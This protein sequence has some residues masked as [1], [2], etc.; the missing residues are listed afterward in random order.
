MKVTIVFENHAGYRKGLIGYHGFSALVEHN[1]YKVLVDTG[2]DGD[3]LLNNMRELGI[4][5]KDID[6]LFI[7]HGHYDH[8]GGLKALLEARGKPLDIYAHPGIF[9]KRIALKP[10]RREIGIPFAREELEE[11]G[12][13]FHLSNR[14]QEFLPGFMSSGEIE[15]TTWDRAVGYFPNGRKDPVRDDIALI[16]KADRGIVVISGCG[17]S[18]IINIVRHAINLTG[19]RILTLIGGFHLKGA[20]KEILEDTVRELKKLDM[21]RLYPGH[22]TGLEE[23]AYLYSRLENVEGIYVGKEIKI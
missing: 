15:R 13:R 4:D 17:H 14:P 18:G 5:P 21:E 3:V 1:G 6:A 19:E 2:T 22:C 8:T 7:T 23:F 20:N 9:E 16:V 10:R 11:L 12:A